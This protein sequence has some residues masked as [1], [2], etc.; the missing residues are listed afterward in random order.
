MYDRPETAQA[1]DRLWMAIRDR[2]RAGGIAAPDGLTR[3]R[4]P[5]DIWTDPDLLLAQTCGL[6]F[7]TVLAGRAD[8]VATP[9]FA[10]H[11]C[12]PG[13]YRSVIVARAPGRPGDFRRWRGARLA[14]NE[15]RSQSGYAA[16]QTHAALHGFRFADILFTGS[17]AAS[18]RAVAGGCADL[19]ALDAIS[20]AMMRRWDTGLGGLI[21]VARTLPTPALPLI[22]APGGPAD[23]LAKA[24]SAAIAA[25]CPEDRETLM[26]TGLVRLD[27]AAYGR[28]PTPPSPRQLHSSS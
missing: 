10:L 7:R 9:S 12:P 23:A 11:D 15:V 17:H 3:G 8:Y 18:A 22:T 2:L 27:P 6:P 28:V 24:A 16:P 13:H 5:L 1:N 25:L 14:V 19:A 20:W 26:L 4:S 21:G